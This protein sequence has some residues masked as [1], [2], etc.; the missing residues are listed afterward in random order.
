MAI[1]CLEKQLIDNEEAREKI[2][3]EV[4]ILKKISTHPN[5][6]SLYEVFE[7]RKYVFCVMEYAS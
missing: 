7:N 4:N 3:M 2:K 6:I 1:K 5:I